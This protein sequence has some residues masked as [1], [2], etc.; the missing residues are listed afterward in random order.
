MYT[1]LDK[2]DTG[3]EKAVSWNA[4]TCDKNYTDDTGY[5]DDDD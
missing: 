5:D 3:K 4:P 1:G 2:L